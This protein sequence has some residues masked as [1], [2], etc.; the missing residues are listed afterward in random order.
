MA[1]LLT[2]TILKEPHASNHFVSVARAPGTRMAEYLSVLR[3]PR[4]ALSA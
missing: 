1:I 3:L 2:G 4:A